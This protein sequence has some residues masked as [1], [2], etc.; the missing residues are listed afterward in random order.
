MAGKYVVHRNIASLLV[1]AL[2]AA[3]ASNP[4]HVGANLSPTVEAAHYQQAAKSNY[5]PPVPPPTPGAPTS[6]K[7]PPA[8]MSRNAGSARSSRW[9][10]AAM[11]IST[12]S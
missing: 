5:T 11:N 7:P 3:C 4:S 1:L 10:P 9:N 8:S 2:L 12:A 6:P